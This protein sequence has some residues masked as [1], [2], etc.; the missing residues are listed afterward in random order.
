MENR[1]KQLHPFMEQYIDTLQYERKLSHNTILSYENDLYEYWHFLDKEHAECKKKSYRNPLTV[2]KEEIESFLKVESQKSATTRA[3]YFTVIQSFYSFCLEE[4]Y[5]KI[6]P[7]ETIYMPKLPQKIPVFLSYEEVEKLLNMPLKTIYDYRTKAMLELLYATGMRISELLS[8]TFS[9]ID[10]SECYVKVEG[11]GSK[12]RIIPLNNASIQSLKIYLEEYRKDLIKHGKQYDQ[13]FLNNR[14]TPITRQGFFKLLKN[15]CVSLG[16][17]K[18]ISPHILRHSFATHL[19]DNGADL[20]VIQE[21]LGHSSIT[22]T[23]IYTHVSKE[24]KKEEYMAC[25]PR[26]KE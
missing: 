16:I 17:E 13:L 21:L 24:H 22:T 18:E 8:L 9:N 19:L 1:K 20:R 15:L 5:S 26:E 6:N 11:K 25:F 23:Q 12:E 2:T 10:F 14:G 3:H 4:G 7:C